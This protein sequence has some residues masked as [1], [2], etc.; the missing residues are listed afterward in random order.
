MTRSKALPSVAAAAALLVGC[1]ETADL[2]VSAGVGPDPTLPPPTKT[3]VPTVKIAPAVGW[4]AP[5][6]PPPAP[7]GAALV[8]GCGKTAALPASAG[9]AP[10]PPR[11][12][13]TKTLVPTVKIAP[14]VGWP[15]GRTPTPAPGLAVQAFAEGLDHR[16]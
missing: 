7:P 11:P 5:K 14:A 8:A 13:R 10:A 6:A 1:G 15:A 12:P 16:R 4:P 9:V 2:P 3:L